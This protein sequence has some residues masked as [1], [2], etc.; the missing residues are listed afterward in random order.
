[1]KPVADLPDTEQLFVR[2]RVA[3]L[4]GTAFTSKKLAARTKAQRLP[5][6]PTRILFPSLSCRGLLRSHVLYRGVRARNR[7][8][9]SQHREDAPTRPQTSCHAPQRRDGRSPA[10]G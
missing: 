8:W 6:L 9:R 2:V 5:S 10:T 7:S 4:A 1:M 3:A